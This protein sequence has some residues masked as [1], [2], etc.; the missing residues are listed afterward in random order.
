M[1]GP[2]N[3]ALAWGALAA[4]GLEVHRVPGHWSAIFR[5]PHVQVLAE[6][7]GACARRGPG[8][9]STDMKDRASDAIG[10][11]TGIFRY[12][13][14]CTFAPAARR[15]GI[16]RLPRSSH[17][18]P[19]GRVAVVAETTTRS[20]S[21][22]Q[23]P[24]SYCT[25]LS[26]CLLLSSSDGRRRSAWPSDIQSAADLRKLPVLTKDSIRAHWHELRAENI[27]DKATFIAQTGGSTGEPMRI[28][29]VLYSEAWANMCY[30]RGLSWGGLAPA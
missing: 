6:Q 11:K 14:C 28:A 26:A 22:C 15:L 27:P 1:K 29:K 17:C 21:R 24:S 10:V 8:A 20:F 7:L 2:H 3:P 13:S 16:G 18:L 30:E 5:E 25:L 19:S 9:L 12:A 23:A 4:G